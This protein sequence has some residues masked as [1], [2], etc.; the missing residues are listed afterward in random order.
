MPAD[1]R[2]AATQLAMIGLTM[3]GIGAFLFGYLDV[4]PLVPDRS[5]R[6]PAEAC[7]RLDIG[8]RQCDGIVIQ[9][10]ARSGVDPAAVVDIELRRPNGQRV[11]IGGRLV[12]TARLHLADGRSVDQEVWCIGVGGQHRPWCTE[13]PA[14][15]LWMGAN[16]DVPCHETARDGAP[17]VACATPMVLDPAAVAAARPL[18]I[19]ALDLPLTIGHHDVEL[20]KADLANGFLDEARFALADPAPDGVLIADGVRLEIEP[21]DP[22]RPPLGNVYERGLVAGVEEVVAHLRFDVVAAPAGAVLQ[23]RDVVVR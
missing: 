17:S 14:L 4:E 11:E 15:E 19:D 20:G 22:S 1:T 10:I 3:A 9:A 13:D 16:H 12:A 5:M 8:P 21:T 23:V 2:R 7:P 18:L 6:P